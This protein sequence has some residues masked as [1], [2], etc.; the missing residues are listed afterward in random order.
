MTEGTPRPDRPR[1][2]KER[3]A[4]RLFRR[5]QRRPDDIEVRNRIAEIFIPYVKKIGLKMV[6]RTQGRVDF[7]EFLSVGTIGL[8]DAIGKFDP[9]RGNRFSTYATLRIQGQI[10]DYLRSLDWV[11]RLGRRQEKA[12]EAARESLAV[13]LGREPTADE[14]AA[15]A[16]LTPAE[17]E[18]RELFGS[19][20]SMLSF[21]PLVTRGEL[22]DEFN[23]LPNEVCVSRDEEADAKAR[24]QEFRERLLRGLNRVERLLIEEYYFGGRTMQEVGAACGLSESRISQVHSRLM[25]RLR[26]ERPYLAEM[27]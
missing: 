24:R 7:G 10:L 6:F 13:K 20:P 16:G 4:D 19:G 14:I 8:L 21:D 9:A 23:S 15:E 11:P 22:D 12:L 2:T 17:A 18:N 3:R 25:L 26:T 27:L 5:L 1:D